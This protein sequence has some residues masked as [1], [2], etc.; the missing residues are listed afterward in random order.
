M[1]ISKTVP[2]KSKLTIYPQYSKPWV[3][4]PARRAANIVRCF[5][6]N[7]AQVILQAQRVN[8]SNRDYIRL[9]NILCKIQD[10]LEQNTLKAGL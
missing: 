10:R 5:K 1:P 4:T 9:C 3:Y 6:G 2:D 7:S 8:L